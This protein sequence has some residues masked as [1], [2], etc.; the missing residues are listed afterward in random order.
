MDLLH[1]WPVPT[2][3]CENPDAT[4]R[5]SAGEKNFFAKGLDSRIFVLDN[6]A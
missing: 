4:R 3:L 5:G 1:D 2:H 6:G